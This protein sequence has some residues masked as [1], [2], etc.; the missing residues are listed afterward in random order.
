MS[1]ALAAARCCDARILLVDRNDCLGGVLSQCVHDGF[2]LHVL[3]R[4]LTGPE[5][6]GWLR[7][8]I[9]G[10]D[11]VTVACSTNVMQ[12]RAPR[13]ETKRCEIDLVGAAVGGAATVHADTVI[14]ATGCRERTRGQI[15][16][17]GTRPA[18]VMTAGAAQYM[19][20]VRNQMPGDKVI[21]LGS[22]DI[23]LIMARRLAFEGAQVR[24]VLGQEATGL[25]RNHV[26]CIEEMEIP[27]RYGWVVVSVHGRGRLKGVRIAPTR[28]DGSPDMSRVE[29]LRCNLLLIAAGLIPERDVFEDALVAM[30]VD[31]G[32]GGADAPVLLCGNVLH[33]HDLVDGV[34]AE[35]VRV[36]IKAARRYC[37]LNLRAPFSVPEEVE[38][39]ASL[40]VADD[41]GAQKAQL[42]YGG[43]SARIAVEGGSYA[44][45]CT[46]CPQGCLLTVHIGKN[47]EADVEGGM[48]E[49]GPRMLIEFL[50]AP[51]RI[52]TGTVRLF[53][54]GKPLVSV[55]SSE[56][57]P[58]SALRDIA[59]ACRRIKVHAP[60]FRGDVVAAGVGETMADL[61]A[62]DDA[63]LVDDALGRGIH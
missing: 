11:R 17:P 3:G 1:A 63:C 61:V 56:A 34:T 22:G 15:R 14:G 5:Y 59:L 38:R 29:Y 58:L 8:S 4:S 43:A 52:F 7:D 12:V 16:I 32:D 50:G 57:V 45:R 41:L 13:G 47:G 51:R 62:T 39:L 53:G 19:M 49:R 25:Y 33:I 18:G 24:M 54:G 28:S 2:G 10:L 31:E 55:R 36:G 48:C 37:L 26:Q 40:A 44:E 6:A 60:V 9:S 35:A 46:V 21:V 23:G 42:E 20:N 27:I 30:G